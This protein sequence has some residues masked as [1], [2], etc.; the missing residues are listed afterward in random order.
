MIWSGIFPKTRQSGSIYLPTVRATIAL[1]PGDPKKA[2]ELLQVNTP[3]DLNTPRSATFSYFGALY[4][5]YVRG[6][7]IWLHIKAPR[8]P[9]SLKKLWITRELIGDAFGAVARLGLSRAYAMQGDTAKA[10]ATY[11]DFLYLWKDTPIPTSPS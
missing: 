3:Y 5:V 1:N 7:P 2:I 10:K 9:L 6:R 11:Q 4:P 8:P